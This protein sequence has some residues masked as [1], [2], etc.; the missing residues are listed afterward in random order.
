MRNWLPQLRQ[1]ILVALAGLH[2]VHSTFCTLSGLKVSG[3][4]L[5]NQFQ[6]CSADSHHCVA[7]TEMDTGRSFARDSAR[8]ASTCCS[9]FVMLAPLPCTDHCSDMQSRRVLSALPVAPDRF[10]SVLVIMC[11]CVGSCP[12]PSPLNQA[13][14]SEVRY[15]IFCT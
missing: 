13:N 14:Q 15:F 8:K 10:P 6:M 4:E 3:R 11:A 5:L 7:S 12:P 1:L 9:I 2:P